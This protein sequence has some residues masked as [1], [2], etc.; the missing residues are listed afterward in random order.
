M[1]KKKILNWR[2]TINS[3]IQ[4]AQQSS[5]HKNMQEKNESQDTS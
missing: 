2:K 3:Q 1:A 4:E 5:K